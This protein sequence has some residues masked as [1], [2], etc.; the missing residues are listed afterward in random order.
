M[1]WTDSETA[2]FVIYYMV[3][4]FSMVGSLAVAWYL[5]RVGKFRT[6]FTFIVCFLH[7]SVLLQEFAQL[8][9]VFSSNTGMC[10]FMEFVHYYSGL[11]SVICRVLLVTL[12]CVS[13]NENYS[14]RKHL[15]QKYG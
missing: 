11:M 10:I 2:E 13:V 12:Y 1:A 7:L 5:L 3:G 8:P 9:Y 6:P 15:I 14:Y 4:T